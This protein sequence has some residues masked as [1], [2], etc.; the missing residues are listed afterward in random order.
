MDSTGSRAAGRQAGS[1]PVRTFTEPRQRVVGTFRVSHT[2]RAERPS[3]AT[4]ITLLMIGFAARAS[5]VSANQLL[6]RSIA[7]YEPS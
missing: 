2:R 6:R 4:E 5:E 7:T 1:P 3:P